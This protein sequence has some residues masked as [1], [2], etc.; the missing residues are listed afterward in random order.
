MK[1]F[2]S[3]VLLLT[4]LLPA[5]SP[6]HLR[7]LS[8]GA[9]RALNRAA[10]NCLHDFPSLSAAHVVASMACGKDTHTEL[11][12]V[13]MQILYAKLSAGWSPK[14]ACLTAVLSTDFRAKQLCQQ[15]DR[16]ESASISC[17]DARGRRTRTEILTCA[18][19]DFRE[20]TLFETSLTVFGPPPSVGS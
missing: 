12:A 4:L 13:F 17:L 15:S 11:S 9:Q 7:N 5:A 10:H 1:T 16:F 3:A 14:Q 19:R 18:A 20:A 6:G 8:H 2:L